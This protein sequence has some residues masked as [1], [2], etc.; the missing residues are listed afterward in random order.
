M[1][2]QVSTSRLP[3]WCAVLRLAG[4]CT[5]VG[6]ATS[7]AGLIAHEL[8]GHGGAAVASGGEVTSVRL[9]WFGGGWIRYGL[10]DSTPAGVLAI[11]L[12]GIVIELVLGGALWLGFAR[13]DSLRARL[14]R[15]AGAALVI[16]AAWYFATGSWHGYGDGVQL[17]RV[18]AEARYPVAIGVGLLACGMAYVAARL[19]LGALARALPGGRRARVI[20]TAVAVTIAA[21]VQIALAVGEVHVRGDATYGAIMEP[22]RDRVIARE[23]GEWQRERAR[24]GAPPSDAERSAR[25]RELETRHRELP[26]APVL[27]VLLAAAVA[28]GASRPR[29]APVTGHVSPRL[30]L[31]CAAVAVGSIVTVI[32]LDWAFH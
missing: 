19:V 22:E 15:A 11:S 1:L 7:R 14:V 23:L 4:L 8:V 28:A 20:G 21:V 13:W 12:G 27:A 30:V 17:H 18:L 25:A 31:G 9:F 16:H 24:L 32:A 26:F 3:W 2:S 29:A 6:L 10:A 5:A